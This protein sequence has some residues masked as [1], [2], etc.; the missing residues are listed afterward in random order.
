M[1]ALHSYLL[2]KT[3]PKQQ[4]MNEYKNIPFMLGIAE[5]GNLKFSVSLVWMSWVERVLVL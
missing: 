4:M 1:V 2:T 3:V 5:L